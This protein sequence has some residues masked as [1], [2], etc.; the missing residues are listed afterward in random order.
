MAQR[1]EKIMKKI[2]FLIGF[3]YLTVGVNIYAQSSV[4]A[5]FGNYPADFEIA[6]LDMAGFSKVTLRTLFGPNAPFATTFQGTPAIITLE[7]ASADSKT[8]FTAILLC[9]IKKPDTGEIIKLMR[10]QMLFQSDSMTEK[11]YVRYVKF[12]NI[13]NGQ[14]AERYS[15]GTET[16]NA[17]VAGFF[18]GMMEFFWDISKLK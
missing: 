11:S 1:M 6:Y 14:I 2:L 12:A 13:N 7:S 16:Q 5:N 4:K 10:I 9:S 18:V 3:V 15:R 17:E 8:V